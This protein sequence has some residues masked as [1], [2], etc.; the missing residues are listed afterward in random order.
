LS[1][2]VTV[3][4]Y[5]SYGA[6]VPG[7]FGLV[8]ASRAVECATYV[9]LGTVCV[10]VDPRVSLISVQYPL[11][12]ATGVLIA[13]GVMIA[14]WW[15][16]HRRW[17]R[18]THD[19]RAIT[20]DGTLA[21]L[22]AVWREVMNHGPRMALQA[23]LPATAQAILSG[24]AVA[25]FSWSLSIDLS[26]LTAV[27]LSA[28]VYAVV[29]LPISV[30]GLGVREVTLTSALGLLGVAPRLAVALSVLLFL[31]PVINAMVGGV[32]QIR[33]TVGRRAA[34]GRSSGKS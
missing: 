3:Y 29:L 28:A 32:L 6:S 17:H 24:V 22:R 8:L 12:L 11:L 2:V 13:I 5:K 34:F 26:L 1:G 19:R 4:R 30:A 16:A 9:A 21:Q 18:A 27:W 10:L 14:G 31:D 33:S 23:M 20:G 15:Y 25:M 7:S